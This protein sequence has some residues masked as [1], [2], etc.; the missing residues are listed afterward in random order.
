MCVCGGVL[1]CAPSPPSFPPSLF[2]LIY[3]GS[4]GRG[5]SAYLTISQNS[6]KEEKGV[7]RDAFILPGH[8]HEDRKAG[9]P[10]P[11]SIGCPTKRRDLIRHTIL[12]RSKEQ[13]KV[14]EI[15]RPTFPIAVFLAS[16]TAEK[17]KL[18]NCTE[19][20]RVANDKTV[21]KYRLRYRPL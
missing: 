7:K 6:R 4:A 16:E 11:Q 17:R 5:S 21:L 15:S 20:C 14:L 1:F 12:F 2:H 10:P 19:L 9:F 3:F 18:Q 8:S 13:R